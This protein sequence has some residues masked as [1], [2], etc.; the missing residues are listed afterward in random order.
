MIRFSDQVPS[1]RKRASSRCSSGSRNSGCSSLPLT[2]PHSRVLDVGNLVKA[3]E[4]TLATI[5]K[6]K[7]MHVNFEV[8]ERTFLRV[9]RAVKEGKLKGLAVTIGVGDEVGFP[10]QATVDFV[11]DRVTSKPARFEKA[12]LRAEFRKEKAP[13]SG[14]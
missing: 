8:D 14:T 7:P 5:I 9:G 4:T 3:D 13:A 12:E 1:A 2:K 6:S 11:D 10:R